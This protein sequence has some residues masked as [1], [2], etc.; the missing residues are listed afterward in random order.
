MCKKIVLRVLLAVVLLTVG[1][2]SAG[3]EV[4]QFKYSNDGGTFQTDVERGGNLLRTAL[5]FA[6]PA[7]STS[8]VWGGTLGQLHDGS[9]NGMASSSDMVPT[10]DDS[11][12]LPV[13]YYLD[14]NYDI[15]S[16][17]AYTAYNATG[18]TQQVHKIEV[19]S[20]GGGNWTTLANV[21]FDVDDGTYYRKT[22][23]ADSAGPTVAVASNVN[24]I[25]I[26]FYGGSGGLAGNVY[27]E[28]QVWPVAT[29][30][31][32]GSDLVAV[33]GTATAID[34]AV[35]WAGTP[36]TLAWTVVSKPAGSTVTFA[37]NAAS[38]DVSVT[39][40]SKGA[41]TLQ[42]AAT[43]AGGTVTDTVDILVNSNT[44]TLSDSTDS[45]S[46]VGVGDLISGL[47]AGGTQTP[48]FGSSVAKLKD[49]SAGVT[50]GDAGTV[51]LPSYND[52]VEYTF[53][54]SKDIVSIESY[55]G[56]PLRAETKYNVYFDKGSG[57]EFFAAVRYPDSATYYR[58]VT[59]TD[60]TGMLATGVQGIKFEF[61][62]TS[63]NSALHEIDVWGPT[64]QITLQPKSQSVDLGSSATFTVE[65]N[66]MGSQYSP[67]Y[68]WKFNG[69]DIS[70]A[71]SATYTDTNVQAGDLGSYTCVLTN[72][73]GTATTRTAILA[74]K[75]LVAHYK[76]D[77]SGVT[78]TDKTAYGNNLAISGG[79]VVWNTSSGVAN[80]DKK[81]LYF[82]GVN[83][84]CPIISAASGIPFKGL[85][86][87]F[88]LWVNIDQT[89]AASENYQMLFDYGASGGLKSNYG[90]V[91]PESG[92][93]SNGSFAYNSWSGETVFGRLGDP[94]GTGIVNKW[95]HIAYSFDGQDMKVYFNGTNMGTYTPDE[96]YDADNADNFTI[97]GSPKINNLF[98]GLIDDVKI[99]NYARTGLQ[100]AQAVA[101]DSG[102]PACLTPIESDL[103]GNCV[104]DIDD[105]VEF[106]GQWLLNNKVNPAP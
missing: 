17:V 89:E 97:G 103:D 33:A 101:N 15:S 6:S 16:I 86:Y 5:S 99:Y 40:S 71:T 19:S 100:I 102:L 48:L 80:G 55:V 85:P 61:V 8:G 106:A 37:P 38:E 95:V 10:T 52:T 104:V 75:D 7:D 96:A 57:Y 74:K 81:S 28:V 43:D 84:K 21:D 25:C 2:A 12:G 70:G 31:S 73:S 93:V 62:M 13:Y 59:I 58:T 68:Q 83:D 47:T 30:V 90:V 77:D 64:P 53:S 69:G 72:N 105:F 87:T 76:F 66:Y 32:C 88:E 4:T 98:H 22:T 51:F 11:T 24:A 78:V 50:G 27:K 41:Y 46:S 18:R 56:W 91:V 35:S 36:G 45:F 3:V 1:W 82:D 39:F 20:D 14:A 44:L 65:A 26:T 79:T 34:A 9:T 67:S 29:T 23:V 54:S 49:D 60:T 42:L 94:D 92:G 63:G